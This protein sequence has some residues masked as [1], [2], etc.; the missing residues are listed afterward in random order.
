MAGAG[1]AGS[2]DDPDTTVFTDGAEVLDILNEVVSN[3]LAAAESAGGL[4]R[5]NSASR[6]SDETVRIT[7]ED[8]GVGMTLDVVE[9]A[10]DPFFSSRPAG[11]R[12]GL[13]LSRAYRLA[14]INGGRLWLESKPNVG[15]TVHLELPA[16]GPRE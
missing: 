12:R 1:L 13:G 10:F 15:T 16:H 4:V 7:I 8:N 3:G 14:E 6:L 5:V 9:H 2:A 11:R